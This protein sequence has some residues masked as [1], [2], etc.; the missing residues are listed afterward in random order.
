M[1]FEIKEFVL[2]E[3]FIT[4]VCLSAGFNAFIYISHGGPIQ[5]CSKFLG[6]EIR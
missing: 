1:M 4:V 6:T 3:V 2:A 5:H